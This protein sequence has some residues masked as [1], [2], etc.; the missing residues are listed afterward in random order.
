[1]WINLKGT[2]LE[3]SHPRV[4]GIL[5]ATPDSFYA[6]SRSEQADELLQKAS[7]MVQQG[8]D[9]FDLG[10]VSTR[11]G[12]T[13][14]GLN[15][16]LDRMLPVVE[17]INK[18]FPT[19]P[20]SIDTFRSQVAK[21]AILL[22]AALIND[23]SAGEDDPEMLQTVAALQVPYVMM[24]KRGTPQTMSTQNQYQNVVGEVATYFS[25][26]IALASAAGIKDIIIDPGFGFA[27]MGNQNF[28]LL[29]GLR[30]LNALDRPI[31]VGISRKSM[32]YKS[33]NIGPEQALNGTTALHMLALEQGAKFLRVHDVWAAKE[34]IELWRIWQ[35]K[36]SINL[37]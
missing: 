16:E 26:R 25:E 6:A 32:I 19:I 35:Q 33:L 13:E 34:C 24:H 28:E 17:L 18:T 15:E 9:L 31:L 7:E 36:Q 14:V 11:P 21:E 2:L 20:I 3:V 23:I 37:L 8:V 5:N 29:H 12:A 22:G 27:K 30:F 4:M 10:A 1:M